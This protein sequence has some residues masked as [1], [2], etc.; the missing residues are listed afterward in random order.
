MYKVCVHRVCDR[1]ME[2]E[3]GTAMDPRKPPAVQ[4]QQAVHHGYVV[5][6]AIRLLLSFRRGF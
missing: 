1:L 4:Q 5:I 2:D 3:A 6:Y